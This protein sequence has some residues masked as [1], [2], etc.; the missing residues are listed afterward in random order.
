MITLTQ[1]E[2]DKFATYLEQE[3]KS[4]ADMATQVEKFG[5]EVLVKKLKVEAMAARVIAEKLRSIETETI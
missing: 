4:D 3:S 5:P 2:R 1:Q